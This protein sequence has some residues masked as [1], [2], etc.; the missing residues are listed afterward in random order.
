MTVNVQPRRED[1]F[2]PGYFVLPPSREVP[3]PRRVVPDLDGREQLLRNTDE[4]PYYTNAPRTDDDPG[5][6]TAKP[7]TRIWHTKPVVK[8]R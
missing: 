6:T 3:R 4:Y 1:I 7:T 5:P 8:V 2:S